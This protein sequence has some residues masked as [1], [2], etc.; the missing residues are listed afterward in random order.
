MVAQRPVDGRAL[1]G[2]RRRARA[3]SEA[4][5]AVDGEVVAFDGG[6][7]SFARLAAR[8]HRR[9]AVFYY[10]F[11]VLWVDGHDLRDLPLLTRKRLLRKTLGFKDHVRLT[12]APQSRR[13][14]VLRRGLPARLGG[15]DRQARRQHV[16]VRALERLAQVQV[17]ARPGA[18]GRRLHR[19]ARIADALRRAA[20]SATTT[21]ASC[22]T[23]ARSAPASTRRRSTSSATSSR[24]CGRKTSPFADPDAIRERAVTW[25]KPELVAQVGFTEWTEQGRLRHPRF[26]GLRDDKAARDVVREG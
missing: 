13:R 25:V 16:H 11:D 2:D 8:G 7:T 23:P 9:V 18:G 4:R 22:A 12:V 24:S 21:A 1:P 15:R 17:R 10:V 6:Q 5:F 14:G 3:E 26:Q 19:A 20:A